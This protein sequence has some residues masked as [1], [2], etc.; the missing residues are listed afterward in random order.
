MTTTKGIVSRD[1][2]TTPEANVNINK[3]K[4]IYQYQAAVQFSGKASTQREPLGD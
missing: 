4:A 1:S 3:R 2:A